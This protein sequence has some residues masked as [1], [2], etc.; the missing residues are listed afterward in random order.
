M[1]KCPVGKKSCRAFESHIPTTTTKSDFSLPPPPVICREHMEALLGLEGQ[2]EE[3]ERVVVRN[4]RCVVCG[5]TDL[6]LAKN[7]TNNAFLTSFRHGERKGKK[8]HKKKKNTRDRNGGH[9][10]PN[11]RRTLDK[12]RTELYDAK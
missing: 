12:L 2:L 10:I 4:P 7:P 3:D 11:Q 1:T 9:Y 8:V 5:T 6:E